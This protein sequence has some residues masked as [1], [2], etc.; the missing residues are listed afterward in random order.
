[1]GGL[2]RFGHGSRRGAR[3][4][5]WRRAR[6]TSRGRRRGGPLGEDADQHTRHDDGRGDGAPERGRAVARRGAA[7]RLEPRQRRQGGPPGAVLVVQVPAHLLQTAPTAGA[8]R[9]RRHSEP[10][11]DL[12]R[13][14]ILEVAQVERA[15]VRLLELLE[16]RRDPPQEVHALRDLR[17]RRHRGGASRRA[18]PVGPAMARAAVLAC[19]VDGHPREPTAQVAAMAGRRLERCRERPLE[20]V[21]RRVVVEDEAAHETAQVFRVDDQFVPGEARVVGCLG[22]QEFNAAEPATVSGR[23]FTSSRTFQCTGVRQSGRQR[24]VRRIPLGL[25]TLSSR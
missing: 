3:R 18:L 4:R 9:R 19:E 5:K 11:P 20:H 16:S 22:H 13:R 23:P 6:R 21:L 10:P 25:G 2:A 17:R 24:L 15:P 14:Q 8:D 1:M 12:R 7:R